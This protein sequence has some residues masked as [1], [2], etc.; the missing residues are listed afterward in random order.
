[1]TDKVKELDIAAMGKRI[2]SVREA[3]GFTR[4]QLAESLD[5]SAQFIADI[6]YGNKGISIKTLYQ[7]SQT[8]GVSAEYL[9]SGVVYDTECNS[10]AMKTC[11]EIT[12]IINTLNCDNLQGLRAI[13]RIY[14]DRTK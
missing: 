3:R 8:L 13:S 9:L 4:E 11:E 2:R 10:D 5:L 14:I 6:E 12:D 1:M 7:L